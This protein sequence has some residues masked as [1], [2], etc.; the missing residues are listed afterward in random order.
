[1][2]KKKA[3]KS[4]KKAP[5]KTRP[6][7][8]REKLSEFRAAVADKMKKVCAA[9]KEKLAVP[10]R[11]LRRRAW[12][13]LALCVV[14]LLVNV[15]IP[16]LNE[17]HVYNATDMSSSLVEGHEPRTITSDKSDWLAYTDWEDMLVGDYAVSIYYSTDTDNNYIEV[18][19]KD[20]VAIYK[21]QLS[22]NETVQKF[23]VSIEEEGPRNFY[24]HIWYGGEGTLTVDKAAVKIVRKDLATVQLVL[25]VAVLSAVLGCCVSRL[26]KAK[27]EDELLPWKKRMKK[28]LPVALLLSVTFFVAGPISLYVTNADEFW[29]SL[30]QMMPMV[31][32]C[33][34]AGTAAGTVLLSAVPRKLFYWVLAVVFGL[35]VALYVEGNF[36]VQNLGLLNG[37]S[38]DWDKYGTWA[39]TDTLI[40]LAIILIPAAFM[41]FRQGFAKK[42]V[43]YVSL[44]LVFTQLLATGMS[45]ISADDLDGNSNNNIYT[46]KGFTSFSKEDN[47]LILMPDS[48]D[49]QFFRSLLADEPEYAD[50]LEDFIWYDNASD[51]AFTTHLSLPSIVTGVVWDDTIPHGKM[52]ELASQYTP[53]YR[54]L[55]ENGYDVGVY[56]SPS[57]IYPDPSIS[58]TYQ[59]R[60]YIKS[61]TKFASAWMGLTA[62]RYFPQAMKGLLD[63]TDFTVFNSIKGGAGGVEEYILDSLTETNYYH[64]ELSADNEKKTFHFCHFYGNHR[65]LNEFGY[66]DSIVTSMRQR[67]KGN[68]EILF[69]YVEQMKDLGIYDNSTI[70]LMADHGTVGEENSSFNPT[71]LIKPKGYSGEFSI[72]EAPITYGDLLPTFLSLAGVDSSRYGRTIFEIG[73]DEQRQRES[74]GSTYKNASGISGAMKFT[75]PGTVHASD[76]KAWTMEGI[77]PWALHDP[78]HDDVKAV[79]EHTK[80]IENMEQYNTICA[81]TI[82][83]VRCDFTS[84]PVGDVQVNMTLYTLTD[85]PAHLVVTANGTEVFNDTFVSGDRSFT[86]P[87]GIVDDS[88]T[89]QFTF[90]EA[91]S[92]CNYLI[93]YDFA[94][95]NTEG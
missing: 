54:S 68:L 17:K 8:I 56:T 12:A 80:T 13:I 27:G 90:P 19:T 91:T 63:N 60:P 52:R 95:T 15:G 41:Y 93:A 92:S 59:G 10:A 73:E 65:N 47:I 51:I 72:S 7:R 25:N 70:I 35:G 94:G 76:W 78:P 77:S 84:A 64:E 23:R 87:D 6:A 26:R 16:A 2:S 88:V 34:A 49:A 28:A 21:E 22:A 40:V 57:Y 3:K 79:A 81:R 66:S 32:V 50:R 18:L 20:S 46:T 71:F 4:K 14:L 69:H 74:W 29:F 24:F 9:V 39:A 31:A 83:E 44:F 53:L 5:K 42:M 85:D 38:V 30:G 67:T 1:M 75:A 45:V 89:L 62:F 33:F 61:Q 58:N 82:N 36:L 11:A 43:T 37:S 86:I 48:M 55:A